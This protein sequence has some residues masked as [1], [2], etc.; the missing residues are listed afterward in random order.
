MIL[1]PYLEEFLSL[2]QKVGVTLK[3]LVPVT[4]HL[5]QGKLNMAQFRLDN[6]KIH[7]L[8]PLM[9]EE[10]VV[11]IEMSALEKLDGKANKSFAY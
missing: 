8:R 2:G 4:G 10:A 6:G 1:V 11:G 3:M 7:F 9:N 5:S